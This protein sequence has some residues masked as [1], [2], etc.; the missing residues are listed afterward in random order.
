MEIM[1]ICLNQFGPQLERKC[2]LIDRNR[3]LYLCSV[4]GKSQM[5]KLA[6]MVR[7]LCVWAVRGYVRV[8]ARV[9][10]HLLQIRRDL[11]P[12]TA[13]PKRRPIPSV[14]EMTLCNFAPRSTS[15]HLEVFRSVSSVS[16]CF[17]VF[18]S[19]SKC[20]EV[21][22][23]GSKCFEVFRSVSRWTSKWVPPT[24]D[25]LGPAAIPQVR[26]QRPP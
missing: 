17:E 2:A 26:S 4:A 3:D 9:G 14:P 8:G 18:R 11:A 16:K 15:K 5:Y 20:F 1:E 10:G 22:R 24:S 13:L 12:A 23:S 25:T 7:A 6:T 19:V 21:F